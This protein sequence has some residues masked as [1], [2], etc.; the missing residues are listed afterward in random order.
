MK[1]PIKEAFE[2]HKNAYAPYS[3]FKVGAAVLTKDNKIYTGC[4]VENASYSATVC[5]ERVAVFNAVNDGYKE[6]LMLAVAG[7]KDGKVTDGIEDQGGDDYSQYHFIWGC[8]Y[9][10]SFSS[11]SPG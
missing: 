3:N 4:N 1:Y 5:A 7:G 9:C 10:P 11:S 2:A 6:F 8:V